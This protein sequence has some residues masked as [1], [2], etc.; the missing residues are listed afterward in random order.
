LFRCRNNAEYVCC[1]RATLLAVPRRYARGLWSRGDSWAAKG[2]SR[3]PA[4]KAFYARL[5]RRS[6]VSAPVHIETDS[7]RVSS[8]P[9]GDTDSNCPDDTRRPLGEWNPGRSRQ[10]PR[11][12][13]TPSRRIRE[14]RRHDRRRGDHQPVREK[15]NK[16]YEALKE[17]GM[18]KTR[19]QDRELA[20]RV[21]ARWEEVRL[22]RQLLARRHDRGEEE[23]RPEGGQAAARKS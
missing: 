18:S 9:G 8:P 17:K 19:R 4:P 16:Q 14:A 20:G 2:L 23:S 12:S 10:R 15:N 6:T 7:L 11:H 13:I 21:P 5:K 3:R 1:V 22:G